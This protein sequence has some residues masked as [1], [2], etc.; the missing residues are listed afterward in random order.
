[1][2]PQFTFHLY[3][4]SPFTINDT[5]KIKI[6]NEYFTDDVSAQYAN[7]NDIF[8]LSD[9]R[10]ADYKTIRSDV[11]SERGITVDTDGQLTGPDDLIRGALAEAEIRNEDQI[12]GD[13]NMQQNWVLIINPEH[14]FLKFRLPYSRDGNDQIVRYLKGIVYLQ[15]WAPQ[16]STETR[17]KPVRN[18]N[19]VYDLADWS[20]L[21]YEQ[22]C[23]HHNSI[24]RERFFYENIFTKSN[25]PI[26]YPELLNDYDSI[27]EAFILKLY[28][29][30]IGIDTNGLYQKVKEFSRLITWS[31]NR[32]HTHAEGAKLLSDRR[33]ANTKSI[34]VP[35]AFRT[36]RGKQH[37]QFH[38]TNIAINP[39]WRQN[40]G[41]RSPSTPIITTQIQTPVIGALPTRSP[42]TIQTPMI[43]TLPTRSPA[44]I[45]T[46]MIATLPTR[47]PATI[48]TPVIATRSPVTIQTPVIATRSPA[49]I[50]TPVIVAPPTRSPATIQ[51]PVIVAPPTRSPV[52]IQTPMIATLPSRSPAT[53]QTPVI[54][55]TRLPV[56]PVKVPSINK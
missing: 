23:F 45:Q 47:S 56:I 31:I 11:L 12:W 28:L 41:R 15:T 6:F 4:P 25:D 19:G 20:I 53:I 44:T 35:D 13:M 22:W 8:F 27:S 34:S 55:S 48:Q 37:A 5:D 18:T 10:T 21:E 42:A 29:Q 46:P 16:T 39:T 52:T 51:T 43:A 30:K 50:Q 36:K 9:I 2:F 24:V 38:H 32:Q 26:D 14:A 40:T 17:L 33:N 54:P 1:M 49:T 7:R 3:D